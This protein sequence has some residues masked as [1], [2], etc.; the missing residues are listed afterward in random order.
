MTDHTYR[1]WTRMA[2]SV[3]ANSRRS[4]IRKYIVWCVDNDHSPC[5]RDEAVLEE[6]FQAVVRPNDKG[7]PTYWR[8][9][10]DDWY[11]LVLEHAGESPESQP[12]VPPD[13]LINMARKLLHM[14]DTIKAICTELQDYA[15]E[16]PPP[17]H[18]TKDKLWDELP[19][20]GERR[21]CPACGRE[22]YYDDFQLD[23][24]IPSSRVKIHVAENLQL[25]CGPCN[26]KKGNRV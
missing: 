24:I 14:E 6:F 5:I 18:N 21:K 25:L 20:D 2:E 17:G 12:V 3:P 19:G 13:A 23:H 16:Y 7:G 1:L 9:I 15:S 26:V 8:N 11:K 22:K 4:D 10:C